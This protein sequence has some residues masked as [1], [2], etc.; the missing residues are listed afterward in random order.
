MLT[1]KRLKELFF[2]D[3]NCGDFVRIKKTTNSVN[4]GDVAGTKNF[5][6]YLQINVD[7]KIYK[8]HRLAWLY[9]HGYM[10]NFDI[11]HINRSKTD[12]RIKN[13]RLVTT[14]QNQQNSGRRS[15]NTS[16]FKG[17]SL[18]KKSGKWTAR[19]KIENKYKHLGLFETK[20]KAYETYVDFALKNHSHSI[21][22]THEKTL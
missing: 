1:Q 18:H 2:Y 22:K 15:D 4:I 13:L 7:G 8:N 14:S 20:E 11:D 3:E 5:Y 6:G 16:G 19:I 10:P 17:V 12:N 9:V 21:F